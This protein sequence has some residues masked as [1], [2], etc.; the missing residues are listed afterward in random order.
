VKSLLQKGDW[1][2]KIDLKDDLPIANTSIISSSSKL[3][4][5]CVSQLGYAL[6]LGCSQKVLK[7]AVELLR[8]IG[9]KLVI[10]IDNML[11]MASS[12]HSKS[13]PHQQKITNPLPANRVSRDD[14]ELTIHVIKTPR[15]EDKEN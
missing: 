9:V 10:Y 5:F 1:R 2:T 3:M 12:E 8:T 7:S 11:L 4:Q 15:R 13:S 6:P 14:G